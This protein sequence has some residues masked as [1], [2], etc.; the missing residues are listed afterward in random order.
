MGNNNGL[1]QIKVS[2]E[3][4]VYQNEENGFTVARADP[5]GMVED[6]ITVVGNL[7]SVFPGQELSLKG[8]WDHHSEYGRKGKGK[9]GKRE[10][11]E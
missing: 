10:R 5:N 2:L 7:P 3:R 1:Q 4:I 8:Y 9:E 11:K 6:E